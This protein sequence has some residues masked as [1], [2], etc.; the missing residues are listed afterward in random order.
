MIIKQEILLLEEILNG[1]KDGIG[2][3]MQ[4]YKNHVYRMIH[5]CFALHD[6]TEDEQKKLLLLVFFM[7][8]DYLLKKPGTI[9]HRQF[10]KHLLNPF[11][12]MKW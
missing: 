5:C 11:P 4:S 7:I 9:C 2:K 1:W 12:I 3:D 10:F 6:A 8:W